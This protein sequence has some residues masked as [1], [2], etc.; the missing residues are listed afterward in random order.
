MLCDSLKFNT[1]W[2]LFQFRRSD[3]ER[4]P[5]PSD[6]SDVFLCDR[7]LSFQFTVKMKLVRIST[8]YDMPIFGKFNWRGYDKESYE[9]IVRKLKMSLPNFVIRVLYCKY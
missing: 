6:K 1:L 7:M 3:F 5:H 4:F 9:F 2:H 8:Y